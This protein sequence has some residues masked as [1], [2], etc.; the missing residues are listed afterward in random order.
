MEIFYEGKGAF[1]L[2]GSRSVSIDGRA[3]DIALFTS[4]QKSTTMKLNGPGE[5]EVRGVLVTTVDVSDTL[6]HAI[7][8]DDIAVVHIAA[9]TPLTERDIA[10]VGRADV[11]LVRADDPRTAGA[12]IAD[13]APRVV[14]PFGE[15]SHKIAASCGLKDLEPRR[16]FSWNGM[17]A[18]PKAVLLKEGSVRRR[19]A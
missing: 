6:V 5:Y 19:A 3:A 16:S 12:V 8:L 4:R 2:L 9:G 18:A 11:L 14:I 1:T 17:A 13:L 15:H 7:T 10:S